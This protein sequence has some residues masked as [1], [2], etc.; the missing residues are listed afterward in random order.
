MHSEIQDISLSRIE[1]FGTRDTA[2]EFGTVPKNSGRLATLFKALI[3]YTVGQ[4]VNQPGFVVTYEMLTGF[5]NF[6]LLLTIEFVIV[7]TEEPATPHTNRCT[8]L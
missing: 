5:Q 3:F 4:K 8:T 1:P 2:A 6:F 7:I